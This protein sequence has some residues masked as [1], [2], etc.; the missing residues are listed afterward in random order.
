MKKKILIAA[1]LL[2]APANAQA[3]NAC[4]LN[5]DGQ[6]NIL[7]VQMA[8]NMAN[9]AL[10]TAQIVGN[11]C[12]VIMVQRVINAALGGPCVVTPAHYVTLNWVAS[13][14]DDG[15]TCCTYKVYRST[16]SV[17]GPY[18]FLAPTVGSAITYTDAA[19][20]AG[21]TYYY[22]VTAVDVD[23]K[24]NESAYSAFCIATIPYP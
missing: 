19:V 20:T 16:V 14:D 13:T 21:Q 1:I 10:C 11:N 4:D 24:S 7:D 15:V 17:V 2:A 5:S 9:G 8:M 23:N 3:L 12:N 18:T 6:V 22:V